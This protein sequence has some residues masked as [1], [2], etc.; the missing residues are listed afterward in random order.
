MARR[1]SSGEELRGVAK[2]APS[3]GERTVNAALLP[4]GSFSPLIITPPTGRQP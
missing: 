1:T 4:L 2:D 3:I